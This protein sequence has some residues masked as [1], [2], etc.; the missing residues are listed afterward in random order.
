MHHKAL[1]VAVALTLTGTVNTTSATQLLRTFVSPT[2]NDLNDCSLGAPCRHLQAALAQTQ[3]GGEIAVLGTAG[4]NG[5]TTVTIDKAISIVNPGGYEAGIFVPSGGS[6]IV[7]NAGTSDAVSLIGLTVEGGG[8]G[9]YGIQFNTGE[10]L[11]I[12]NCVI[13]HLAAQGQGVIFTPSASSNLSISHSL[14]ADSAGYGVVVYP[15]GSGTVSAMFNRVEVN[16]NA[17]G[18]SIAGSGSTGTVSS[19]VFD[20][21]INGNKN[22]AGFEVFTA[23]GH[24]PTTLMLIHSVVAR[25]YFGLDVE[26]PAATARLN[27]STVTGNN[28]GWYSNSGAS[29]LSYGNNSIDG[30]GV[31][32]TAP[33]SVALK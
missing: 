15:S 20:S 26:G 5:G 16:N 2:G 25:N 12:E 22:G 24:A 19:T 8:T 1:I 32:E 17:G 11:T 33:P 29:V 3:A 7:I 14:I 4:Y 27:M 30:N 21:V 6:G 31:N 13:R 28:I 9:Y 23:T 10:S 18:I